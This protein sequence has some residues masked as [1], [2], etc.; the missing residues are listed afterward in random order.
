MSNLIYIALYQTYENY[1][2]HDWDGTGECPQYWKAKGGHSEVIATN[3]S[4]DNEAEYAAQALTKVNPDSN[5]YRLS[6]IEHGFR[7]LDVAR[8]EILEFLRTN[9]QPADSLNYA[10][11]DFGCDPVWDATIGRIDFNDGRTVGDLLAALEADA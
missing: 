1:G 4:R 3:A 9:L 2:S 11:W 10:R 5:Y 6:L 8:E 7:D